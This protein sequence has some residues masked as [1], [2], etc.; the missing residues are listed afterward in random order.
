VARA[1]ERRRRKRAYQRRRLLA[2]DVSRTMRLDGQ[3]DLG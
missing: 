1:I 2:E 3:E